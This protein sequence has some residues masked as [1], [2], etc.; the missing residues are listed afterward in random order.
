MM[1]KLINIFINK[2][3]C[4]FKRCIGPNDIEEEQLNEMIERGS[5]LI[6][7]RSPQEYK[8][9]HING[10]ICIPEYEIKTKIAN[11]V[12]NKEQR[13]VLYCDSGARSK[14]AQKILQKMNYKS[15]YNL[16]NGLQSD[17]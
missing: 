15:V 14:K 1:I 12:K 13:I 8:E 4:K 5:I 6:D 2:I 11:M 17:C 16:W 9:G 7:V 10:A 3:K